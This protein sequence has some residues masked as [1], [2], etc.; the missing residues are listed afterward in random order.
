MGLTE[1]LADRDTSS[2]GIGKPALSLEDIEEYI[3]NCSILPCTFTEHDEIE[4]AWVLD[5]FGQREDVT[6]RPEV[7]D[8]HPYSL[9]FLTYGEPLFDEILAMIQPPNFSEEP[10]GLARISATEFDSHSYYGQDGK[11]V[12]FGEILDCA[13]GEEWGDW[14]VER[15]DED[16]R[17]MLTARL[18]LEAEVLERRNRGKYLAALEEA[19]I[20]LQKLAYLEM[21]GAKSPDFFDGEGPLLVFGN[22]FGSLRRHERP[23]YRALAML[24]DKSRIETDPTDSF[25]IRLCNSSNR[26]LSEERNRLETRG[27]TVLRNLRQFQE[28]RSKD[29]N[30]QVGILLTFYTAQRCN[31]AVKGAQEFA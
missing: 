16:F 10:Q 2:P 21:A 23:P 4:G 8:V 9:K 20:I 25:Y 12:G 18:R 22:I 27:N 30:G 3:T 24:I 6:F 17:D 5:R 11:R 14:E 31:K 15:I 29:T 28:H 1:T 7:F 13:A 19:R 26:K